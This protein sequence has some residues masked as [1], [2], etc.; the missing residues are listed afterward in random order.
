MTDLFKKILERLNKDM[1]IL[2]ILF[3]GWYIYSDKQK[4]ND[5]RALEANVKLLNKIFYLQ[6]DVDSLKQ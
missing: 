4:Q 3:L 1:L 5:E 6:L 2:I